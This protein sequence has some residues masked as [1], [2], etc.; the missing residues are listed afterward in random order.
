M[1]TSDN[2]DGAAILSFLIEHPEQTPRLRAFCEGKN[3]EV[4]LYSKEDA[5]A[6]MLNL[7]LSKSKYEVLRNA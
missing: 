4:K 6:L 2:V 7:G 3:H 5:L 1:Q